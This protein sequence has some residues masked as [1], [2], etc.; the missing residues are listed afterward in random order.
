MRELTLILDDLRGEIVVED[1][2]DLTEAAVE[3]LEENFGEA[4]SLAC[5]RPLEIIE[6]PADSFEKEAN[7]ISVRIA[8]FYHNS[9]NEGPGRRSSVLFQFCPLKC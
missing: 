7:E 9:L 2:G 4:Q 3:Q 8:G 5:A 1:N 6:P